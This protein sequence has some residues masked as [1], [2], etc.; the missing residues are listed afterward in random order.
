ME[1]IVLVVNPRAG[2]GR[3]KRQLGRLCRALE[4][5]GARVEVRETERPRH[6]TELARDALREGA[7]G[8]AVVGGDGTL[9]EAVNGFFEPDGTVV[10]P[11]AWLGPMPCGTGGDFRK[12][13]GFS[14]EPE[15]MAERLM[16]AVPRPLDAGWLDYTDHD[17]QPAACAFLN[18]AS[19]GISGHVD[20]IVNESPKWM[21]GRLAFF[22]GSARAMVS[23][24]NQAVRVRVDEGVAR[25]TTVFNLAVANGQYFGGGM[26][27]APKAD[28]CDGWFDVVALERAGALGKI[29]FSRALYNGT[30]LEQSGVHYERG[31]KVFAEPVDPGTHVLLDVDGEA[32]GRLPATFELRSGALQIR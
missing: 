26:Q 9:N 19:F 20:R 6:A 32:P 3:A 14:N 22:L 17:G 12:T 23:Y 13:F 24:R 18:I 15:A 4:H 10:S 5:H 28:P 27:I 29:G 8:I 31:V 25:E 30:I 11:G 2:A 21:G 16:K 7:K 1:T